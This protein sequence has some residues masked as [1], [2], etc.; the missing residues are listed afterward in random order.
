NLRAVTI[1]DVW[2]KPE[3][4]AMAGENEVT[5]SCC[6]SINGKRIPLEKNQSGSPLVFLYDSR[7]YFYADKEDALEVDKFMQMP[8]KKIGPAD[9]PAFL[10]RELIPLNTK[11]KVH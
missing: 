9:W 10:E 5:V 2:I 6:V 11:Y 8:E 7:V 4:E 1:S 3:F